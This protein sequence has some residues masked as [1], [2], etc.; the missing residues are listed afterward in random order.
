MFRSLLIVVLAALVTGSAVAQ[1]TPAPTKTK[2][3]KATARASR[4]VAKKTTR[5][6]RKEARTVARQTRRDAQGWPILADATAAPVAVAAPVAAPE[7]PFVDRP[8]S[9][10]YAAPGMGVRIQTNK[11]MLPYSVVPP[12]KRAMPE[13]TLSAQK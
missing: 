13:T 1:T 10:V 12:R 5:L 6:A 4:R 11:K 3:A 9:I 8:E 2:S 7:T